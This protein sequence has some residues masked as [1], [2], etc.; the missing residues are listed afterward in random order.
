[1]LLTDRAGADFDR[2]QHSTFGPHEYRTGHQSL[3]TLTRDPH[4]HGEIS[5]PLIACH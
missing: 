5:R 4:G 1:M 2:E 3:P